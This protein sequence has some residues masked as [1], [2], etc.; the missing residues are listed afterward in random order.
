MSRYLVT[1]NR[2]TPK[3]KEWCG[4]GSCYIEAESR[5]DAVSKVLAIYRSIQVITV[6]QPD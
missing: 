2:I 1:F 3:S 5:Q 4:E 6:T